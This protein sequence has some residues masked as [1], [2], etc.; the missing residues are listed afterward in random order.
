MDPREQLPPK[1]L[2]ERAYLVQGNLRIE[3]SP[4]SG[5]L[6]ELTIPHTPVALPQTP[7]ATPSPQPHLT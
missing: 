4:E 2:R 3:S 7:P 5:T 6:I 1:G